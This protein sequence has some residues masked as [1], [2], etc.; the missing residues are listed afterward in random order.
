MVY[1]IINNRYRIFVESLIL[2]VVIFLI[3]FSIGYYVENYR[4][5]SIASDYKNYEVLAWDLRILSASLSS[6]D[7]IQC[8]SA[9]KEELSISDKIY[10]TGLMLEKYEE[11]SQLTDS[12][13]NEKKSYGLLKTE[14]WFDSILLKN[15]CNKPF[16]TIVYFYQGN[17]KSSSI[18]AEQKIISNV[19]SDIKKKYGNSV[20]LLPIVAD[21]DLA[22]V[23]LQLSRYNISSVPAILINEQTNLQGFHSQSEI[24]SHLSKII[25]N[26]KEN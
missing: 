6:I 3:G 16:D 10:N 25:L 9:I 20:I 26:Y 22:S 1:K 7:K 24:E 11:A 2:A 21:M 17:P 8:E 19:L 13:M 18:V 4:N 12:L 23:N 5:S 14:L 15:N